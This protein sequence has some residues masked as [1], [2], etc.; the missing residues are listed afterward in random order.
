MTWMVT[1][2]DLQHSS[3]QILVKYD[4]TLLC[5]MPQFYFVCNNLIFNAICNLGIHRHSHN[6]GSNDSNT[7][8]RKHKRQEEKPTYLTL[9]DDVRDNLIAEYKSRP[10]MWDAAV[11]MFQDHAY[12]FWQ[13]VRSHINCNG[14]MVCTYIYMNF[15]PTHTQIF[16]ELLYMS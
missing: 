4:V 15:F 1:I 5:Y 13:N 14:I 11:Q 3:L 2:P 12:C 8:P 6:D 7:M 9:T 10:K 16:T